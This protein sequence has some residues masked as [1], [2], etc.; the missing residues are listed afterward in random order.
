MKKV[1]LGLGSNMGPSSLLLD[2]AFAKI[3]KMFGVFNLSVSRYYQTKPES[4]IS[5]RDFLN[6][7]CSLETNL[8]PKVFFDSLEEIERELGKV[9]KGREEPR[10]IDID[11]LLFG[12]RVSDDPKLL[13]PHPRWMQRSFVLKPLADLVDCL[14]VPDG[15]GSV[16]SFYPAK[17]LS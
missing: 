5:Q 15:K 17:H 9:P 12:D 6:A 7:A 10:P 3:K 1:F 13:L 14:Q 16:Y 11:L 4:S 2:A 8:C